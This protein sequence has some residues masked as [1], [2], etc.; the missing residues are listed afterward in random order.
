MQLLF[1]CLLTIVVNAQQPPKDGPKPP[2]AEDHLKHVSEKFEKDLK[3]SPA[4]KAKLTAAY[5]EFF[6]GM[7]QL[8][9]KEGKPMPPPPPPPPPADKAAV[10][11]LAKIRDAQV[12]AALTPAQYQQYTE[13]EKTMRP[14]AP[15]EH[16]GPPP[17]DKKQ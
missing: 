3:L 14:L 2:S 4:Q 7:E 5:K 15:G 9:K 17:G 13:L 16:P 10:E 8:R 11:K 6:N 12:K 1:A